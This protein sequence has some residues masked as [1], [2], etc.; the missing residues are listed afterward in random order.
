MWK[1][2][3]IAAAAV[4]TALAMGLSTTPRTARA[5]EEP[6]RCGGRTEPTCRKIE[7]CVQIPQTE[8]KTCTKDYYYFTDET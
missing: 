5:E 7:A 1:R 2:P 4:I 3:A 8:I 6:D